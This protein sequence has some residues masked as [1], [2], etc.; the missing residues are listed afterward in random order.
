MAKSG[1]TEYYIHSTELLEMFIIHSQCEG[2]NNDFKTEAGRHWS[3]LP[4][5]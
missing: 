4:D 1:H 5:G 2:L 3:V